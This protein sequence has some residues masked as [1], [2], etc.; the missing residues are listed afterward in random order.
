MD[1]LFLV[2]KLQIPPQP[3]H[4]VHRTRLIEPLERGL[5]YYKLLLLTAPAGY[6]KTTLLAQWARASSY[7]IAWL[8]LGEEDNDLVRFFRSLLSAWQEAQPGVRETPLGLLLGGMAPDRDA[9]LSAFLNVAA[10]IADHTVFVLDD[11]H[12]LADPTIH[13]ALAFLLDHVPP[14]LHFVLAVRA[15]PPLPLARYRVHQE[16]LEVR[17]EDLRFEPEETAE[18]LNPLM[19]LDRS[20]WPRASS[21][22]RPTTWWWRWQVT[23]SRACL[24][25]PRSSTRASSNCIPANIGTPRNFETAACWWWERATQGP[26][27]RLKYPKATEPGYRAGTRATNP[28][29]PEAKWIGWSHP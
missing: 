26:R 13:E 17:A 8:S 14:T 15:M 23:R 11:Y 3:H 25:S 19:G 21:G 1:T 7:P 24:G 18:F 9:V 12:L 20:S 10:G 5:P 22:S 27:S 4:T 29:G 28:L 2:H 6:G 16:L